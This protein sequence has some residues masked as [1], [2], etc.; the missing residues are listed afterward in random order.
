M[1]RP[2]GRFGREREWWEVKKVRVG[3]WEGRG[4]GWVIRW[5]LIR[6]QPILEEKLTFKL[7]S[8]HSGSKSDQLCKV[9]KYF[10][11]IFKDFWRFEGLKSIPNLII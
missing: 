11:L 2:Q 5:Q 7:K 10:K 9:T 3:D 4:W 1:A 6:W 8:G